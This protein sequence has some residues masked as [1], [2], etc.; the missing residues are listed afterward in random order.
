MAKGKSSS[1]KNYTSK[2]ERKS[3]MSNRNTDPGQRL[4]NQLKAL[5]KGRDVVYTTDVLDKNTGKVK[6]VSTR[7]SGK[8]W[9]KRRAG[10]KQV[11]E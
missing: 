1:G 4:L 11:A 3:S 6:M 5:K 8:D 9:L 10:E 7:V 2:G